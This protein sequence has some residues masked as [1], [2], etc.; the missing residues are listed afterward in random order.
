MVYAL[1]TNVSFA[2]VCMVNSTAV[3]MLSGT[4]GGNLTKKSTVC[5]SQDGS[6][7]VEKEAVFL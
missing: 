7:S 3:D 1:R 5:A 6:G 4:G 2:I